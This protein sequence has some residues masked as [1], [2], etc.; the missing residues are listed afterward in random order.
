MCQNFIKIYIY[1]LLFNT[2]VSTSFSKIPEPIILNLI[3]SYLNDNFSIIDKNQQ[4]L[5]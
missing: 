4:F 3:L 5:S 2:K 1:M